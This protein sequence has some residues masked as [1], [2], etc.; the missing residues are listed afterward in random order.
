MIPGNGQPGDDSM[1]RFLIF[2]LLG[3]LLGFVTFFWILLQIL[4]WALGEENTFDLHQVVLIPM[5]YVIGIVPALT[6]AGF[7][8]I[9]RNVYRRVLWTTLFGYLLGL[10]PIA[11]ALLMGFV[12]GTYVLFLG[13]IGGIPAAI[14]SWLSSEKKRVA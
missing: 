6:A 5:A 13:L 3:P 8:H 10:F 11:S 9:L 1:K 4:N 7:D 14:C 2:G 12:H